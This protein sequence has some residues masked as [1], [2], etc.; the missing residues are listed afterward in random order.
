MVLLFITFS[1]I[2]AYLMEMTYNGNIGGKNTV[3][4]RKGSLVHFFYTGGEKARSS[5]DAVVRGGIH[6]HSR[7]WLKPDSSR[8]LKRFSLWKSL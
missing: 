2:C 5:C 3:I 7:N 8:A 1:N 6:L 4:V